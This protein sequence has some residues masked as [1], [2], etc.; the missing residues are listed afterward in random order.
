MEVDSDLL[1]PEQP[2]VERKLGVVKA[3]PLVAP[4]PPVD[5]YATLL[6]LQRPGE[7]GQGFSAVFARHQEAGVGTLG[8]VAQDGDQLRLGH[9]V[10]DVPGRL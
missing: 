2:I 10:A 1:W 4:Y 6:G 3:L 5:L 7:V 9:V 8:G